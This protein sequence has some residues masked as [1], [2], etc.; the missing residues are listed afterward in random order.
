VW[1]WS[2]N[3]AINTLFYSISIFSLYFFLCWLTSCIMSTVQ[4][5]FSSGEGARSP[6]R[7]CECAFNRV[8]RA[9]R[10]IFQRWPNGI[11]AG[12]VPVGDVGTKFPSRNRMLNY[13]QILLRYWWHL[14]I[15]FNFHVEAVHIS[16]RKPGGSVPAY[17]TA[18]A[19]V[20]FS[21][22]WIE[23]LCGW[24]RRQSRAPTIPVE[25]Q[26]SPY[27]TSSVSRRPAR[28]RYYTVATKS[29][30]DETL[31]GP[32][33]RELDHGTRCLGTGEMWIDEKVRL[34]RRKPQRI[35]H[36]TKDIIRDLM[37]VT[38]TCDAMSRELLLNY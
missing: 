5:W 10:G 25:C 6:T 4:W 31:F 18:T 21:G 19:V 37:S 33:H 16:P 15:S 30:V 38:V 35:Q 29:R 24:R 7:A 8:H 26:D 12:K 17:R 28:R 2:I 32:A 1:A 14:W 9:E 23:L 3:T 20:I 22:I 27:W 34:E 36:I 11:P 13:V